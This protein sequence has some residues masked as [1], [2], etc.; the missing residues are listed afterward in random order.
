MDLIDQQFA[1]LKDRARYAGA[2]L[3]RLT[4]GTGV[5]TIPDFP[6]PQGWNKQRT[7]VY[8]VVPVGY[9]MARPDTFWTDLDLKLSSGGPALNTGENNNHG[10]PQQ[11]RWFSWHPATWNPNRDTLITY[12]GMI[13]KRLQDAR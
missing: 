9:P 3:K 5:V 4:N 10:L 11:L 6:L 1:A 12:V 2:T 13:A 8:F 7:T